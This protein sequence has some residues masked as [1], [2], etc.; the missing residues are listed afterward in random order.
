MTRSQPTRSQPTPRAH[1]P[2]SHA[3]AAEDEHGFTCVTRSHTHSHTDFTPRP[4][5]RAHTRVHTQTELKTRKVHLKELHRKVWRVQSHGGELCD[6]FTARVHTPRSHAAAAEDEHG[7][8][9]VTRSHT[10]SH[11]DFT[12]RPSPHA[13]TRVHTQTELKTRKVHL[14]ELQRKV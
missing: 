5:P 10:R 14:K 6:A 3:T 8:T 4:T 2:R 7:F 1:T 13:H 11:T 12:P 9:C